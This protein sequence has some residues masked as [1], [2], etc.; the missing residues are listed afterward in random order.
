MWRVNNVVD[1]PVITDPLADHST[2]NIASADEVVLAI[3]A[4]RT[5][6]DGVQPIDSDTRASEPIGNGSVSNDT[7]AKEDRP[8]TE[9]T[10]LLSQWKLS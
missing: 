8:I 1:I 5:D 9:Q 7:S 3:D 6:N 10:E 2:D 4:N